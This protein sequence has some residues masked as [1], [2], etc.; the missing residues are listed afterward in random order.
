MISYFSNIFA[1]VMEL[2]D[3]RDSKSRGSNTVSVRPRPPAPKKSVHESVRIFY[4]LPIYS[5]LFPKI[6]FVR[7]LRQVVI[8]IMN[9]TKLILHFYRFYVIIC[10][11]LKTNGALAQLGA[12]HTGSVGV[13]GSSPLCSTKGKR[14]HIKVGFFF[15]W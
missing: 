2:A 14:S 7:I 11:Q 1:G 15:F 4:L 5:S 13:K 3:V 8:R 12:H 6:I 10:L 9:I